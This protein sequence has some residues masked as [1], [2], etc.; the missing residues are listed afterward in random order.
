MHSISL[1]IIA[2]LLLLSSAVPCCSSDPTYE[3]HDPVTGETHLCAMCP[4]GEH[5]SAHCTATS[6]TECKPCRSNH[7][8]EL[9]NYL[10]R[11]LYCNTYCMHNM[12]VEIEC[13]VV[14]DRVCRCKKG[15]YMTH[16]TCVRHSECAP[17][18]GVHTK[19]TSRKDTICRRCPEGTFSNSSSA[20]EE[21]M[22]HQT[23]TGEQTVLMSGLRFHDTVCGT[24]EDLANRDET[25]RRF[26][27]GLLNTPKMP[28]KK[29]R[30]F[31]SRYISRSAEGKRLRRRGPRRD[32]I[33][34]WLENA[35]QEQLIQM[36]RMLRESQ[37]NSVVEKL[38]ERLREIRQQSQNCHLP[39][40]FFSIDRVR[41]TNTTDDHLL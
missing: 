20:L 29:I 16:D 37:F 5:M 41:G 13:S 3:R 2:V 7:Y 22:D 34:V 12:E 33:R 15:Y 14:S 30:K 28:V 23:C 35:N 40:Y 11:C 24:C 8:T 4:P 21:C 39:Q 6:P 36:P 38:E 17:G 31:I 10:P 32:H 26:L 27:I 25:L 9:W 1:L 18:Y 19:G